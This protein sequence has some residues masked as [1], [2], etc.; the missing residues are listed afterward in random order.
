MILPAAEAPPKSA[1][2]GVDRAAEV[3]AIESVLAQFRRA[4]GA[5]DVG[6]VAEVWPNVDRAWLAR[7]FDPVAFQSLEFDDCSFDIQRR[8]G[9]ATCRGRVRL[10]SKASERTQL[11]SRQWRFAL[12]KGDAGWV[13]HAADSSTRR[14]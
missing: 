1:V 9:R 14:D 2:E 6:K 13:I 11:E 12:V 8:D 7:T 5:L 3:A 10:V 4:Y